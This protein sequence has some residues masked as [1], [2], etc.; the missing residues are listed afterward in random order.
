MREDHGLSLEDDSSDAV[1][2]M[3]PVLTPLVLDQNQ[4]ENEPVG[5][6]IVTNAVLVEVVQNHGRYGQLRSMRG[7]QQ[8]Y[9]GHG[10]D[11]RSGAGQCG[12]SVR[13][14]GRPI[15]PGRAQRQ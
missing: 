4:V 14:K 12:P 10:C 11:R 7:A 1:R 15:F 9:R 8:P 5:T 2:E 13:L 3:T 6:H